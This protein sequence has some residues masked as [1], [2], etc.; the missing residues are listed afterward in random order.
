[1]KKALYYWC[2]AIV[3]SI[4]LSSSA[5]AITRNFT[6][7]AFIGLTG[8]VQKIYTPTPWASSCNGALCDRE[9]KCKEEIKS[10][11]LNNGAVWALLGLNAAE[12]NTICK[13]GGGQFRVE[14]GFDAPNFDRKKGWNFVQQ[15]SK[16]GCKCEYTCE[17][18]FW[19]EGNMCVRQACP[20]NSMV[21]PGV[22]AWLAI[23]NS[24]Y[25]TDNAGGTR[26]FKPAVEG[27]CTF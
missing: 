17:N 8:T 27:N 21:N 6:C 22:P 11:W 14:Y 5:H 4:G 26:F 10:K 12:Q 15:V 2:S 1:M 19:K 13:S 9:S 24:G 16:T 20:A 3:L 25:K 7:H 18:G 23:G